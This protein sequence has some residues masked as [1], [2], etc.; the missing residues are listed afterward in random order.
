MLAQIIG[1]LMPIIFVSLF[2]INVVQVKTD[3]VHL[4]SKATICK[5]E[6]VS[7]LFPTTLNQLILDVELGIGIIK[8]V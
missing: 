3:Y 6:N 8:N 4:A 5:K 7:S 2:L 1:L